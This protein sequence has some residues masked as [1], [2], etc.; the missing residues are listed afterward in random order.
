M[1]AQ[2]PPATPPPA[3]GSRGAAR[4]AWT[5]SIRDEIARFPETAA[6][7]REASENLKRVSAELVDVSAMLT[8]MVRLMEAT[9]MVDRLERVEKLGSE[10]DSVRRAL[11]PPTSVD[12]ALQ[13]LAQVE[14]VVAGLSNRVLRTVGL[15]DPPRRTRD[16]PTTPRDVDG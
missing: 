1:P 15:G 13:R 10:L 6:N 8:R 2:P 12:E 9:G 5:A 11:T 16:D 14:E 7:I 3:E 4:L